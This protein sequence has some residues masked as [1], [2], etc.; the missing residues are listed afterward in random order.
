MA[1]PRLLFKIF[2][3][4]LEDLRDDFERW[5]RALEEKHEGQVLPDRVFF[6]N[7][8][9]LKSEIQGLTR[10]LADLDE[11]LIPSGVGVDEAASLLRE[12]IQHEVREGAFPR[13]VQSIALK[14]LEKVQRY[15]KEDWNDKA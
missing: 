3:A 13:A 1:T 4:E 7:V 10:L 2:L 15:L 5:I 14:K 9:L 8:T 6:E 12:W 11:R